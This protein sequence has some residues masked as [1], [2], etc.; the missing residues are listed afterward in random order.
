MLTDAASMFGASDAYPSQRDENCEQCRQ[1]IEELRRSY[2]EGLSVAGL[3][4]E[5]SRIGIEEAH[6]RLVDEAWATYR[7]DVE[8]SAGDQRAEMIA[9]ARA[10]YGDEIARQRAAEA[11]AM[12]QEQEAYTAALRTSR[13]AYQAA[14][15]KAVAAHHPPVGSASTS[16]GRTEVPYA[17]RPTAL[18][19][20]PDCEDFVDW[21]GG[22]ATA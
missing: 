17:M 21:V 12:E 2:E 3:V 8:D 5:A 11:A 15:D 9:R 13:N 1:T 22:P 10:R 18:G 7:A 4:Y 19:A 20:S 14:V 16:D 6:G